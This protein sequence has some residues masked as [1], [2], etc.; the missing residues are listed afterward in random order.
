MRRIA[1]IAVGWLAVGLGLIGVVLPG[2]PTT[3]FML[4][5]AYSFSKGSPRLRNWL[6]DHATFGPPIHDWE[7]RGAISRR[8]KILAVVMMAVVFSISLLLSLPLWALVVQALCL[9]GAATFILTRP[10]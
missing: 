2:L 8:A 6:L 9:S 10:D 1:Y 5:A 4:V 3:P 7:D